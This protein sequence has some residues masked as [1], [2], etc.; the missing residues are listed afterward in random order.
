M[1]FRVCKEGLFCRV[2]D[3]GDCVV[4]VGGGVRTERVQLFSGELR[5]SERSWLSRRA[6]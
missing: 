2:D 6:K 5:P 1:R 4:L 3:E